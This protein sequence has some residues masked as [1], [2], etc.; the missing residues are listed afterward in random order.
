MTAG[1]CAYT[2]AALWCDLGSKENAIGELEAALAYAEKFQNY[3]ESGHYDSAMQKGCFRYPLLR[4]G[5]IMLS[6]A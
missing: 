2:K 6:F 1:M 4:T 5:R 3:D